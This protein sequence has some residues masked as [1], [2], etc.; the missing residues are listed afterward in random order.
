MSKKSRRTRAKHKVAH[1]PPKESIKNVVEQSNRDE[2]PKR[3]VSAAQP[4]SSTKSTS[5]GYVLPELKRIGIIAGFLI[6][7]IIALA[8]ILN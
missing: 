4:I 7:I 8:F 3:T 2:E 1:K 6:L 5:H